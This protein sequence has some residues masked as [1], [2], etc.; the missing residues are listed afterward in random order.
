MKKSLCIL[1]ILVLVIVCFSACGANKS[2]PQNITC[3]NIMQ[4]AQ[5]VAEVP[6]YSKF[7]LKSKD[8]LD[9]YSISLWADGEFKECEELQLISDYAMYLGGATSTY[10]VT[11]LKA[12]SSEDLEKLINLIE[13]RK[14]TLASGDEGFYDPNFDLRMENSVVYS[15]DLFVIFL[16][17]DDNDSAVKAIETL[18]E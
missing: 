7:Y 8:N 1:L 10:E 16:I 13:R 15:D 17:T 4:A 9:A 18:K 3:E 2:F 11:V 6:K 14:Q 12:K 5:S